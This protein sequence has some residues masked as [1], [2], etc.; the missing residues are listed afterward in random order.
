M[1]RNRAVSRNVNRNVTRNVNRNVNRRYV[2][3][4]GRWGYWRNG[5][6]IAV[7]PAV[8]GATYVA[9]ALARFLAP[10]PEHRTTVQ[11]HPSYSYEDFIEG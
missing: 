3:R 4:N 10:D 11:F 7:A 8:A 5:V 9:R 6:W 2:Y 1:T